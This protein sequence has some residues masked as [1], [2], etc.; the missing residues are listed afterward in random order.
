MTQA[1]YDDKKLVIDIL[2]QS[3]DANQSVNY[4]IHQDNKRIRR[5][6]A[7]MAYSFNVC[8][9]FGN[10]YLTDDRTA[11]ALI[12]FPDKKKTS[13]K[14][15]SWDI[16]LIIKSFG[17]LNIYKVLSRESKIKKHQ[18]NELMYYLWFVG[19]LPERQNTGRG[20]QLINEIIKDSKR[21]GR[22]IYLETSTVKN[23]PWYKKFGF[24]IYD[25][26]DLSYRLFFLKRDINK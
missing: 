15:I 11:C 16:K 7:L 24:E 9:Q 8:F 13:L 6:Q 10:V 19:V 25:Q 1:T 22:A 5:I 3:F 21:I 18:P 2:S 4:V 26:L 14:T 17:I 23:I 12:L 20:T